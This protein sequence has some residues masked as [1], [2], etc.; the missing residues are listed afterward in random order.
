MAESGS[1]SFIFTSGGIFLFI[2]KISRFEDE[3]RQ[4]NAVLF[5][6]LLAFYQ[7]HILS[8]YPQSN[9]LFLIKE[10]VR[11]PFS[12]FVYRIET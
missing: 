2:K 4:K 10:D 8:L 6:G 3:R 7:L 12:F 5:S 9:W 11:Q 1:M